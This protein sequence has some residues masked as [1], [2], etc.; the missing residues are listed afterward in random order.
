MTPDRATPARAVLLGG[1]AAVLGV[2]AHGEAGGAVSATPTALAAGLGVVAATALLGARPRSLARL[3]A[4]LAAGQVALHLAMPAGA[5]G[6]DHAAMPA[7]A[8]NDAGMLVAHLA[9]A[10][11]VAGGIAHADRALARAVRRRVATWTRRLAGP[12]PTPRR[13][14]LEPPQRPRRTIRQRRAAVTLHPRRGPPSPRPTAT[15]PRHGRTPPC[16]HRGPRPPAH[17]RS[18]RS[19]AACSLS[20]S[21]C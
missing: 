16:P 4:V 1:C 13:P 5:H 2:A 15:T 8:P 20:P 7:T 12:T 17:A 3:A 19:S 11:L 14:R 9:V 6:H 18:P 21:S 10:V